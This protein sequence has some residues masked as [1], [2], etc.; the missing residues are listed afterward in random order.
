MG[1]YAFHFIDCNEEIF[2]EVTTSKRAEV[3]EA[4]A[5][6]AKHISLAF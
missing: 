1:P 5:R 4:L 3:I 2:Q 6:R